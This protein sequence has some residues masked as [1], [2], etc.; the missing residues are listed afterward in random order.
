MRYMFN[1]DQAYR[2]LQHECNHQALIETYSMFG[3]W[4]SKILE[5]KGVNIH[6]CIIYS[7]L[8]E[9]QVIK[10]KSSF[11]EV[12]TGCMGFENRLKAKWHKNSILEL[13]GLHGICETSK[14]IHFP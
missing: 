4:D 7:N 14:W 2:L 10:N 6:N 13:E 1:Y 11:F 12:D 3:H 9:L 8:L 5:L